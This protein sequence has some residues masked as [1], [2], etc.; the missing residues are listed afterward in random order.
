MTKNTS[1]PTKPPAGQPH[2]WLATTASTAKARRPW[3]SQRVRVSRGW[4][5]RRRPDAPDL[6]REGAVKDGC[7]L[8]RVRA[9]RVVG[10]PDGRAGVSAAV[11]RD[12][13]PSRWGRVEPVTTCRGATGRRWSRRRVAPAAG[14]AGPGGRR[15]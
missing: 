5:G 9:P 6:R 11:G 15:P 13:R 1:T 7:R 2:T 3:T 8:S 4:V 10:S 14:S 12:M